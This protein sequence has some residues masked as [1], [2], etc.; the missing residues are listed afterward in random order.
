MQ[1]PGLSIGVAAG[2]L[3][4]LLSA[5][6]SVPGPGP[7]V[8][9]DQPA[10]SAAPS[11]QNSDVSPEDPV[12]SDPA[13][14]APDVEPDPT[15]NPAPSVSLPQL[16]VGGTGE[17][18]DDTQDLQCAS[19]SWIVDPGGPGALREGIRIAITGA[20]VD[21]RFFAITDS[22]CEDLGENCVGYVFT[23]DSESPACQLAVRT[24]RPL[25]TEVDN[26]SLT[27]AGTV[28]CLDVEPW[29]C[30]AFLAA[31]EEGAGSVQLSPPLPD[32]WEET[33][34]E[35]TPEEETPDDPDQES[36][37]PEESPEPESSP[38]GG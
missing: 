29:E 38:T 18:V 21:E 30:D 9:P 8:P 19:V 6:G 20:T 35:E 33:P 7:D 26:T 28:E 2:L 14:G 5:C 3:V 25:T 13:T 27:M 37:S 15:Q 23:A 10:T 36:E 1:P 31:A 4:T 34:E 11:P 32:T 16:P 24:K 12:T 22:G 17:F